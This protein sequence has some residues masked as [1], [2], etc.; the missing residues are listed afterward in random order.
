MSEEEAGVVGI[1]SISEYSNTPTLIRIV[2][3]KGELAEFVADPTIAAV[4]WKWL[5]AFTPEHI[6]EIRGHIEKVCSERATPKRVEAV[7]EVLAD[8]EA[9]LTRSEIKEKARE[10]SGLGYGHGN[11]LIDILDRVGAK[12]TTKG[13]ETLYKPGKKTRAKTSKA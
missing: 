6:D 7:K 3:S 8:S 12:S 2:I 9:P 4:H 11:Q 1:L 13:K 10:K 5:P